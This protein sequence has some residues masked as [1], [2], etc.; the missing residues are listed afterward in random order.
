MHEEGRGKREGKG[1]PVANTKILTLVEEGTWYI[2]W[3]EPGI[4]VE[5]GIV[6]KSG[7]KGL[8]RTLLN[9]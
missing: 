3:R 4:Y 7:A 5:E 2:I 8:I 6:T 9:N 1:N